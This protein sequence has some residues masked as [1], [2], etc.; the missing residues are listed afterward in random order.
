MKCSQVN[1]RQVRDD[2]SQYHLNRDFFFD[3]WTIILIS[4]F[5]PP[6]LFTSACQ[7]T[8]SPAPLTPSNA[9]AIKMSKPTLVFVPGAWHRAEIWEKVTSLLEQQQQPYKCIPIELPST[10]GDATIG[11]NDDITAVR[12]VILSE[13]KHGRDVILVVHSYGGAVG[14]SA[15]KGLIM[16][17]CGFAQMG[18]SFLD[19]IGGS[20]PPLWRFDDSG[21]AVLQLPARESFYHDLTEGEGEYWVSRLRKQSQRVLKEGGEWVYDGW[22]D[23]PVWY[24]MTMDDRTF[25]VEAQEIFAKMARGAGANVTVR[26]VVSSHSP[27]LSRPKETMEFIVEAAVSLAQ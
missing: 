19:A 23:V 9:Q 3:R 10:G 26:E 4:S 2:H 13:T 11:I 8:P 12:N 25:P 20:P 24:L 27:M 22:M 1:E 7:K 5:L 14:Q 6:S 15:V 17:A 21:F 16:T 18:S